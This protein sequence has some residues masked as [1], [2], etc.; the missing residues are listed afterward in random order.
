MKS[1]LLNI[2]GLLLITQ[3]SFAQV[4]EWRGEGR[5]GIY[6]GKDLL[7]EW[8]EEGPKMIWEFKDLPSGYSHPAISEHMIYL[9]GLIDSVDYI[10]AISLNGKLVWKKPFGQSWV[11]NFRGSRCTPT[12]HENKVYVSSGMGE[13]VCLDE[14]SGD[15]IWTVD[16]HKEYNGSFGRFGLAE[17]LLIV[18]NKVI[19]M[20][21]GEETSVVAL[22][23][24]NG[25]LIW[26]TTAN[27][28]SPAYLSPLLIE[29]NGHRLIVHM[30]KKHMIGIDPDNGEIYWEFD[31][32]Q[33][34]GKRAYNNHSTTPVYK[35]GGLFITSGYNHKSI[36][37]KLSND[38]KN[39][40][41]D[42]INEVLDGHHGGVVLIDGYIYG[43]TWDNNGNGK[44]ACVD[45]NTGETKYETAWMNK[46][47]I[48]AAGGYLYCFD[49]KFGNVG[50]VKVTPEEFKIISSFKIVQ[51]KKGPYWAHPV[52][53]RGILYIRHE[54]AF[55][56]YDISN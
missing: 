56:A 48:V 8:P 41:V 37:F 6:D 7:T 32:N 2:A 17:S 52:I 9:T 24:N 27:G 33:Y 45:W 51:G 38:L 46:G 42:W 25:G 3:F 28:D 10:M 53:D 43:S 21:G 47:S 34:A 31:Y 26:K 15:I 5:T 49:E 11:N 54:D 55:M 30:T 44:W 39:I 23:K 1:H 13:I 12:I 40:E 4:L 16:A 35:D 19:Y 29:D 50:L 20:T 36:K 14:F 22:D 18:D